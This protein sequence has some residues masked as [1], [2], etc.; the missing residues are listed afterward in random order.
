MLNGSSLSH[1]S[2]SSRATDLLYCLDQATLAKASW[3][4][5]FAADQQDQLPEE[6]V[7]Q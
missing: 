7:A 4:E 2:P 1:S 6:A 5:L 3:G